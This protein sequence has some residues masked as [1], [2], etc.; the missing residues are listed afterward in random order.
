MIHEGTWVCDLDGCPSTAEGLVL[1]EGWWYVRHHESSF[2]FCSME[3]LAA[4]AAVTPGQ[5]S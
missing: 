5:A 4:E 2:H 1:P 3:C